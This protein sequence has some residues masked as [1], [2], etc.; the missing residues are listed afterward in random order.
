MT[1]G[2]TLDARE[3]CAER[4]F[5]VFFLEQYPRLV[6]TLARIVGQRAQAEELAADAFCRLHPRF[7]RFE[8]GARTAWLYR[9]AINLGFDALRSATRRVRRETAVE[10][11]SAARAE[12]PDALRDLLIAEQRRRVRVVLSRLPRRYA[13]LLILGSLGWPY[14][15]AATTLGMRPDSVYTAVA[16]AKAQFE[17]QYVQLFGD[18]P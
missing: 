14:R 17:R 7:D 2:Q 16:R 3:A 1:F 12:S 9:T 4:P 6:R 13:R 18:K 11:E 8:P 10:R 5:E 15:D